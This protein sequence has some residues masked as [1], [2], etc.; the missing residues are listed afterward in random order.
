MVL[1]RPPEYARITRVSSESRS[2]IPPSSR[3]T[4]A[5]TP[6]GVPIFSRGKRRFAGQEL[7]ECGREVSFLHPDLFLRVAFPQR[8]ALPFE[9][10]V[11]DRHREG[12]SDFVHPRI[13]SADGARIVVER[14]NTLPQVG[15]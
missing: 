5:S 8:D 1:A 7:V 2:A 9:R 3:S 6:R 12:R 11:V 14:G 4:N 13:P 15:V 10:L